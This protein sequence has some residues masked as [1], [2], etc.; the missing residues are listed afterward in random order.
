MA[1]LDKTARDD[2]VV[3]DVIWLDILMDHLIE[4]LD[5]LVNHVGL[6]ASLDHTREDED[7]G[8]DTFSFHLVKD[9]KSFIYLSHPLVDLCKD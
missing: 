5:G 9:S 8:F 4:H 3:S 6:D 1:I 2:G 7:T